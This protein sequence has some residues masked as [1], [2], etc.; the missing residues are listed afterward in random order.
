MSKFEKM[1]NNRSYSE[2][3]TEI[4][5]RL[6]INKYNVLQ[7]K[8][9]D[10]E[11]EINGNVEEVNAKINFVR[12]EIEK[13]IP[14]L[15]LPKNINDTIAEYLLTSIDSEINTPEQLANDN[16]ISIQIFKDV[17]LPSKDRSDIV[18][19]IKQ[20][21]A[22]RV[23]N[24][25]SYSELESIF[26]KN[27]EQ[28]EIKD[29]Q[30]RWKGLG[31]IVGVQHHEDGSTTVFTDS[32]KYGFIDEADK[33]TEMKIEDERSKMQ[34]LFYDNRFKNGDEV[35]DAVE[36]FSGMLV[37]E[38]ID[39]ALRLAYSNLVV[40]GAREFLDGNNPYAS[41]TLDKLLDSISPENS[42][43][44]GYMEDAYTMIMKMGIY[45][46]FLNDPQIDQNSPEIQVLRNKMKVA[47]P[48]LY[49]LM[50][51]EPQV[52]AKIQTAMQ[53]KE[54][55]EVVGDLMRDSDS[56]SRESFFGRVEELLEQHKD[57]PIDVKFTEEFRDYNKEFELEKRQIEDD[58]RTKENMDR[59]KETV[60]YQSYEEMVETKKNA[61][62]RLAEKAGPGVAVSSLLSMDSIERDKGENLPILT[63]MFD[64]NKIGEEGNF[65]EAIDEKAVELMKKRLKELLKKQDDP[66][67]APYIYALGDL[68]SKASERENI[69]V[70]SAENVD[71]KSVIENIPGDRVD[72]F[73]RE[74]SSGSEFSER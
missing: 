14:G 45:N 22:N 40:H 11:K 53:N 28:K 24:Q 63:N 25:I 72:M 46:R 9:I 51:R 23:T 74:E 55:L 27:K 71:V 3:V 29:I 61:Y 6:A 36:E 1:K 56:I 67:M 38:G 43:K 73:S 7:G 58:K 30:S 64:F 12:K 70:I 41:E 57:E 69:K 31:N 13:I 34:N 65:V 35:R 5:S 16:S 26:A 52:L 18:A 20:N 21:Q 44:N 66:K 60:K 68:I 62:Y 50:E 8:N 47:D 54:L 17:V 59:K 15:S 10:V 49:D 2:K 37:G 42:N 39:A 48:Q 32:E 19:C 4:A 33:E